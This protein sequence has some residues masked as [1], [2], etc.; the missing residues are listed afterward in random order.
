LGPI[1]EART[2]GEKRM[3]VETSG[4]AEAPQQLI[5]MLHSSMGAIRIH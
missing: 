1:E 2:L 3:V 4:F 5:L